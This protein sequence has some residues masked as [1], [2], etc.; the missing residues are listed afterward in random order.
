MQRRSAKVYMEEWIA[1]QT[2]ASDTAGDVF[3]RMSAI[4]T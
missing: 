3:A 1:E 4:G 2:A